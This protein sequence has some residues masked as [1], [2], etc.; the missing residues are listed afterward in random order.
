MGFLG[1]LETVSTGVP[2]TLKLDERPASDISLE[3]TIHLKHGNGKYAHIVLAPQP[4]DDFNEPLNWHPLKKLTATLIV[5]FGACLYAAVYGRL[6][7]AGNVQV[8]ADLQ[9]PLQ[10]IIRTSAWQLLIAGALGP[11]VSAAARKFGKRPVF[12]LSSIFGLTGSIV[13]A[14]AT[15][16]DGFLAA[17]LIQGVSMTAYESLIASM[18]GDL[19]FVHE[20]GF[21]VAIVGFVLAVVANLAPTVCGPITYKLGWRYL[22]YLCIAFSA[23][24]LILLVLFVPETQ[25]H[26]SGNSSTTSCSDT[27]T[28]G[29]VVTGS[30][31][32]DK[33]TSS[34]SEEGLQASEWSSQDAPKNSFWRGLAVFN[35]TYCKENLVQ[36]LVG[37]FAVCMNLAVFWSVLVSAFL[38][39]TYVVQASLMAQIFAAPP[40]LLNAAGIGYLFLGPFIGGVLGSIAFAM[41]MDPIVRYCSR[42]NAGI[43]EPEYRLLGLIAGVL[44]GGGLLGFGRLAQDGKSY[45]ITATMQALAMFGEVTANDSLYAYALDAFGGLSDEIFVV[46]MV[47]K[48]LAFFG[49]SY[50]VSSW[51]ASAGPAEVFDVFG[52]ISLGVV[53]SGAVVFVYGKRYRAYWAEHN[54]VE[55][56]HVTK[57]AAW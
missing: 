5:G 47:F 3:E 29:E 4:S 53:A 12:I 45:Y 13:G 8:A 30:V 1:I 34:D 52:G 43:Y 39:A 28:S 23:C 2:G 15:S 40:Y 17:R 55:L 18:L 31:Q 49:F 6:L 27:D 19:Y 20:R 51:T 32:K 35:E 37:P 38:T 26:R 21:Y 14:T 42:R 44:V 22:F 56:F 41:L 9:R 46:S 54:L 16:F 11:F 24:Q 33:A 48:N 36:L 7:D 10:D 50:F 25:Y 57:S